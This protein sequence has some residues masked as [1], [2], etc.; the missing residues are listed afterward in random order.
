MAKFT[1]AFQLFLGVV[2]VACT[3]IHSSLGGTAA[4]DADANATANATA[5]PIPTPS[6]IGPLLD[7][8][9]SDYKQ[10][11]PHA[12]FLLPVLSSFVLSFLGYFNPVQRWRQLR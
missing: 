11:L 2:T 5:T 6:D 7:T 8:D 9:W 12:I 10:V 1:F 4:A 3:V